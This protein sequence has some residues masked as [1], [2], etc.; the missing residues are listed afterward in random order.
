MKPSALFVIAAVISS[1]FAIPLNSEA[2]TLKDKKQKAAGFLAQTMCSTRRYDHDKQTV[3][4]KLSFYAEV[5]GNEVYDYFQDPKV[6]EA[7]NL[8][9]LA[10][11]PNCTGI[12]Q[13]SSYLKRAMPLLQQ[14]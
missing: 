1:S 8:L 5:K 12:D 9:S 3:A 2:E 10:M 13:K 11:T 14:L 7:S 4:R 6:I